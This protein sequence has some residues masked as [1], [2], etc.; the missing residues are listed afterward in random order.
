MNFTTHVMFG[1]LVGTIFFGGKPE[2]ILLVGI[3]SAI[4]D[5]DREYGFFRRDSFRD[6]QIHRALFHNFVSIG[7]LYLINPFLGIGAFLHTLL[8]ALTT[9]KDRGIE[10]LFPFTRLVKHA[11][12]DEE[13]RK[14]NVPADKKVVFYQN[15]LIADARK[16]DKDLQETKPSPWRRTYGPAL[17][18]A[19]LDQAVGLGSLLL[20][21]YL[22]ILSK[23]GIHQF[24]DLSATRIPNNVAIPL[25]IGMAGIVI[26]L[27]SGE[28]D[29]RRSE[30]RK[31]RHPI[32]YHF[33]FYLSIA[34]MIVALIIGGISNPS[35]VQNVVFNEL[36]YV[37]GGALI[38]FA[39]ASF[40]LIVRPRDRMKKEDVEQP[41]II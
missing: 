40:I 30:K 39:A 41:S 18:S 22:L 10:W 9:A 27:M 19:L 6:K 5:M 20:F 17:S 36:P 13:M 11:L 38:A 2:I 32:V 37:I 1:L 24:I 23:L 33:L 3:G 14:L 29:R 8:D 31:E 7:V 26:E 4:P 16:S 15:D 35:Y 25:V 12:Y 34:L 28:I 21:V